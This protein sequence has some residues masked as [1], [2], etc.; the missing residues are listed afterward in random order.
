MKRHGS[1]D[2]RIEILH[3]WL[4]ATSVGAQQ[5]DGSGL[6]A[7]VVGWKCEGRPVMSANKKAA[8]KSD[9]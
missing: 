3:S 8:L 4:A 7:A 6:F 9:S 5:I 2:D 1:R